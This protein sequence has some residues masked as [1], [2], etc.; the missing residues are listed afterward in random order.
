MKV[1]SLLAFNMHHFEL[2]HTTITDPRIAPV[3]LLFYAPISSPHLLH[4]VLLLPLGPPAFSFVRLPPLLSSSRPVTLTVFATV[5]PPKVF[6][7]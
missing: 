6:R 2:Y 5:Y 1:F 4:L 7:R 3:I